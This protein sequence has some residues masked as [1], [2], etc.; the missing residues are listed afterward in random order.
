MGGVRLRGMLVCTTSEQ[1][2]LV[3]RHLP[4]HVVL[5]RAEPG[6]VSFD[7]SPSDD[8]LIWHVEEHFVDDA[9]FTEHQNRV[10]GSEWGRVTAGIERRYTI[11]RGSA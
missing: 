2:R 6:C 1:A 4:R 8:A 11:E 3:E 9:A 5:T 10:V 7:V